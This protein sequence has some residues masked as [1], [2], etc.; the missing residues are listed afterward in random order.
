MTT[1]YQAI[2]GMMDDPQ[3]VACILREYLRRDMGNLKLLPPHI[4]K[5]EGGWVFPTMRS[6]MRDVLPTKVP[7]GGAEALDLVYDIFQGSEG[8]IVFSLYEDAEFGP[9][10]TP[11]E[12][13]REA[14]ELAARDGWQLLTA[15][16]WDNEDLAELALRG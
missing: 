16:P 5:E 7:I 2:M 14:K 13:L 12:A 1:R 9:F 6:A 10:D 11:V 8:W 3:N 15:L 4:P